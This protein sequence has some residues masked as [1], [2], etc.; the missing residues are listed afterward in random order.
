MNTK[1]KKISLCIILVLMSII[2]TILV[3]NFDVKSIGPNNSFIGFSTINLKFSQLVGNNL[4]WYNITSIVGIIPV[5]IVVLYC[6]LGIVQLIKRKSIIK[7]DFEI[8]LLG[9]FYI[10]VIALYLFF[11]KFIV[12]YRP[13]LID[14]ILEASYPSSHTLMA[15]FICISANI[16]NKRI[17]KNKS[18][19]KILN[20]ISLLVALIIVV[21]R[22]V[23]GVHWLTD[24]IGGI[25]IS[26]TLLTIFNSIVNRDGSH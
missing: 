24:I 14:G 4:M 10:V 18:I 5:L 17:F 21:G 2:F 19:T 15:I 16:V 22:I 23:S 12:N 8:V 26:T 6:I 11:E 9:I 3:L 13:I 7:V 25:L 20:T 1:I